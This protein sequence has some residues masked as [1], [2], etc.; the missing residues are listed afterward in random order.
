M[1]KLKLFSLALMALFSTSLWADYYTPTANE[2]IYILDGSNLRTHA[3]LTSTTLTYDAT[4]KKCGDPAT[5][6]TTKKPMGSNTNGQKIKIGNSK[7]NI[8]LSIAGCSQVVVCHE[9]HSS[10]HVKATVTPEGGDAYTIAG[11]NSTY[12][13]SIELDGSESYVINLEGDDGDLAVYAVVLEKYVPCVDIAPA[14]VSISGGGAEYSKG[15]DYTNLSVSTTAGTGLTYQWYRNTSNVATVSEEFILENCTTATLAPFNKIGTYYYYCVVSNC[16]GSV[17]SATASVTINAVC[18][19]SG[20]MYK[21]QVKTGL[22]DGNIASSVPQD[23]P[24]TT[25]NYLSELTGGEL[26][27]EARNNVNRVQIFNQNAIGF[28]NGADAFLKMDLDCDIE[29]GD[30]IK[31]A[32]TDNDMILRVGSESESTNKMTLLRNATAVVVDSKLVGASVLYMNRSNSSPKITYFEIYRPAKYT[33][34]WDFAGGSCSA[35]EGD[36]YTATG[37]VIEGA[38]ITYPE[39]NSMS[40]DG[41]KFAGWSSSATTMPGS[42]LTITAQWATVYTVTYDATTGSG[43]MTDANSPYAAGDE[44]TLLENTFEAPDASSAWSGWDVYKTGEPATKVEVSEGKFTMPAYNVTV[45]AQWAT[46]YDVKFF[47]G[48]GEPDV[49]IGETQSIGEGAFAVAPADPERAGYQFAGW[50]YDATKAH[51]VN[52]DEYAITAVTNFT[53]I[54]EELYT[55]NKA[56]V[57]NGTITVSATEAKEGATV[58]LTATPAFRYVFG[59]WDVYKTGDE[60]TKVTVTNNKFTMP[61]YAVTVSATFTADARKQILYLTTASTSSDKLYAALNSVDTYNIIV[62]A[63]ASQTLTNYDLVVLH[64]SISGNTANPDHKDKKQV[65]LDIPT[66]TIPVLN[67]KSYFYTSARW[68]W[69]EPNAGTSVTGATLNS[70]YCNTASHPIFEGVTISE[71]FVTLFSEAKAKAMQPIGSFTE[72]KEGYT[73]ATTPNASS[74]N[75]CAIQELTPAQRGVASGK[76]LLISIGNENGCFDLLTADGQKLLKN[77]AAYL[78]SDETWTPKTLEVT[79]ADGEHGSVDVDIDCAAEGD[80]ITLSNEPADGYQFVAYDVYKTGDAEIKVEVSEGKF[81]MPEYAVTVSATFAELFT[82]TCSSAGNGSVTAD[83]AKAIAGETVTLTL[84]PDDGY[85]VASVTV[86]GGDPLAVSENTATFT[87]PAAAANV[88]ATFSVATALDNTDASVKAVKVLRDGQIF[89]EKN[90]H[91]YNVFGTCV[92]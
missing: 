11:S 5:A 53:A 34:T 36:D 23:I 39:N 84:A 70:A 62:E 38:A 35:T 12:F 27:I 80:E 3:A 49:Q 25:D 78:L 50:S 43:T 17:T 74:G 28:A 15:D 82:I 72:G 55:I 21:F 77:A 92:K 18:P 83:K 24:A 46:A 40:K 7:K 4:S 85:K 58:T 66:T 63:P 10:R 79:I 30:S 20:T 90:G 47:Q 65:I 67:T 19:S 31:Y 37:S 73:L 44:V 64:E 88:V 75:G 22:T 59:A 29:V 2:I 68:N 91:V 42:D 76:Y 26:T 52:V 57:T 81:T 32:I 16:A 87:M 61:E 8:Q 45:A 9:S 13:T 69:G 86:N 54:W 14:G 1:K 51:I 71:G 89:I 6:L 56:A 33:L 48:Y 60:S 41:Y